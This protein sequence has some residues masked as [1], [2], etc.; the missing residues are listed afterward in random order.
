MDSIMFL[1][2]VI[3]VLAFILL[4]GA[5]LNASARH[6]KMLREKQQKRFDSDPRFPY[7]FFKKKD[8]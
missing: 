3:G 4:V 7:N 6:N 5:Y 8:Y 1:G 2:W